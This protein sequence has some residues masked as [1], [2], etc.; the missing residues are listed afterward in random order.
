MVR[1]T[2]RNAHMFWQQKER[3]RSTRSLI[4]DGHHALWID[5]AHFSH[6]FFISFKV[7]HLLRLAEQAALDPDFHLN[8]HP[9]I[10]RL[11]ASDSELWCNGLERFPSLTHIHI[12]QRWTRDFAK[13]ASC[14]PPSTRFL[15]IDP[16]FE[17]G[18]RSAVERFLDGISR[19]LQ[20]SI[21]VLGRVLVRT[22]Y[23]KRDLRDSLS[24]GMTGLAILKSEPTLWLDDSIAYIRSVRGFPM[25]DLANELDCGTLYFFGRQLWGPS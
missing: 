19:S 15:A 9:R 13:F 21:K 14:L 22:P 24:Q 25:Q 17:E 5:P 3:F 6:I 16:A 4:M 7:P 11:V 2:E 8:F 10:L 23:V 20:H 12:Q 18:L 1:V